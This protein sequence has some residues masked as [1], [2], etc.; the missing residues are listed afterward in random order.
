M[1]VGTAGYTAALC[2]NA[3][4]A[5]GVTPDEG[6]AIVTG[7]AGGVGSVGDRAARQGR[8]ARHRLDGRAPAR[9]TI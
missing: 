6:P 1:A 8:L 5:A 2:V 3:L 7:A 9:P 4:V